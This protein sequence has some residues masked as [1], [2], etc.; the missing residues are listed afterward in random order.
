[1]KKITF[2]FVI[3]FFL[4]AGIHVSAQTAPSTLTKKQVNDWYQKKNGYQACNGNHMN[5]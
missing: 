4:L 5:P 3:F 1:M 2:V